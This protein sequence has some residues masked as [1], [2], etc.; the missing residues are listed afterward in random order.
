MFRL[1]GRK[2][3]FKKDPI[4]AIALINEVKKKK[5]HVFL[6]VG[7]YQGVTSR[8]ICELLNKINLGNFKY[9]GIDIFDL[10]L[11][12]EEF[13]T[14][15]ERIS[16]PFKWIYFNFINKH[17]PDSFL[18]VKKFLDK[19]KKN[20]ELHK[21]FSDN[22]LPILDLK[23]V[24]FC[25]LDGG[26]SYKTVRNDLTILVSK[27]KKNSVIICDDY[28]QDGYG[29]KKAVDELLNTVTSIE[30]LNKRLVKIIV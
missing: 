16:N 20:V 11:D 6:E 3:S 18:G 29:V 9:I 1:Y 19:F 24:D 7:V 28:D 8:N 27:M 23:K 5:P 26:H 30:S 17:K 4:S 25:F 12:I 2:S 15:H 14:K 13:T 10:Q 21:G 22:I